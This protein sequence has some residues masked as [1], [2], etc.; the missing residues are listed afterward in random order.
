MRDSFRGTDGESAVEHS[1]EESDPI[2]PASLVLPVGPDKGVARMLF[3]HGC[4]DDNSDKP[5]N[6]DQEQTDVVQHRQQPVPKDDK[7]GARPSDE[8]KRNVDVPWF[9]DKV[10]MEDGVHLHRNVGRDRDNGSQVEY[11]S[12]KVQPACVEADNPTV[13]G[14]GCN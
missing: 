4:N 13:T 12:E 1:R 9:D 11:P 2:E 10:R 6:N 7:R 5:S 3:W 8:K 14:A